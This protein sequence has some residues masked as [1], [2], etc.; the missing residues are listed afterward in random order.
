VHCSKF[1]NDTKLR[2]VAAAPDGCAA[3]QKD[4]VSLEDGTERSIMKLNI[5]KCSLA[6]R[7]E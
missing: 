1:A 5:G 2:G 6:S 4:L 7:Q 3:I